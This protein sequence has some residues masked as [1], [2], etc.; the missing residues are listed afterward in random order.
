MSWT[1][2]TPINSKKWYKDE[3]PGPCG[4][5][6]PFCEGLVSPVLNSAEELPAVQAGREAGSV[7]CCGIRLTPQ[8]KQY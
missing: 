8:R 2:D 5:R 7:R 1:T 3:T 6:T 4:L